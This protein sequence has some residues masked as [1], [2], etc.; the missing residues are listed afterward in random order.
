MS[1]YP[2]HVKIGMPGLMLFAQSLFE[3]G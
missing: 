1:Q 2:V 3:S